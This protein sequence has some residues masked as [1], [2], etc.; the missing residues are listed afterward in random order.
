MIRT[1]DAAI[2]SLIG[3]VQSCHYSLVGEGLKKADDCNCVVRWGI[4]T[5]KRKKSI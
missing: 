5:T 4:D 3:A 1:I 2:L